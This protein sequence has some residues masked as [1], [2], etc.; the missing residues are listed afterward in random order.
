MSS[1]RMTQNLI[2]AGFLS[3][4]GASKAFDADADGYCRAEGA[5]L[6]V[7]RSLKDAVRHGDH[8]L[9][10][11][12]GTAVNQ[13]SN[14][15]AIFVPDGESQ[16]S[17]YDKVLAKSGTTPA[18]VTYVESHGT[19]TQVGDPI[20]FKSI[21]ETFG[22]LHR[23]DEVFVG[24]VKDNIGHTEASSG[25][26]SLIKTILM[27]QK[28]TIPKQAN[29]TR[30]NPKIEP[31]GKD[32]VSIPTQSREWKAAKRI[33]LINNYGAGGN[34]AAMVLQE[35]MPISAASQPETCTQPSHL[36]VFISGKTTEAVRS[37]CLRLG[38]FLSRKD[39]TY[40]LA[41]FTYNLA[42]KQS[43][44]LETSLILTSAS[45]EELSSQLEKAA[46]GATKLQKSPSHRPSVVLCFGGQDGK[47]AH[48]SKDLYD[49]S[50]LLQR[51][52][53]GDVQIPSHSFRLFSVQSAVC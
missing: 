26:A 23:N 53:V 13:G 8:I 45:I 46:S 5:G 32:R 24:S 15:S 40:T 16:H 19:G 22:G 34:N 28:S 38:A 4:T 6:V 10:I 47:W 31:L 27:M 18:A 1:S 7:L 14:S 52:I 39:M 36:P 30:L 35:P 49:S 44:E 51:H 17:L 2:G 9:G 33:A 41:D 12:T 29:F 11:I 3:P 43:R 37:Y 50:V 25:V 48:I 20:E 21:R 42:M